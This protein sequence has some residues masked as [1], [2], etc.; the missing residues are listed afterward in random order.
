MALETATYINSFVNSNPAG[1]DDRST[2]DDHLRLI[3]AA[4]LRTWPNITGQVVATDAQMNLLG[5][6]TANVQAELNRIF[7]GGAGNTASGTVFYARDSGML[8]SLSASEYART[9]ISE[10][11]H[12]PVVFEDFVTLKRGVGGGSV[13]VGTLS[14]TLNIDPSQGNYFAVYMAGNITSISIG[15][16]I[17]AGQVMSIRFQQSGAGANTVGGW[18]AS[19]LFADGAS[20]TYS[21][22][23][24]ASSLALIT[25][26]RDPLGLW[27][28]SS[29]AFG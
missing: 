17:S 24:T 25:L 6:L 9:S 13:N 14:G 26:A 23:T 21:M 4:I 16:A 5:S 10:T 27:L 8:G 22:R 11:F 19:V 3:K 29:R 7:L 28:A 18:P 1:S 20:Q 2:A 15:P 12:L